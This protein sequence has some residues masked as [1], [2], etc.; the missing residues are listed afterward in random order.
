MKK[1]FVYT[2]IIAAF[3][4]IALIIF[5]NL[6]QRGDKLS[7]FTESYR[8]K[9]EITIN[10]AGELIADKSVD[11]LGPEIAQ[12]GRDIRAS[13]I[14]IQ[15]LI[16]EGTVVEK[17]DY[18]ATLDRTQYANNLTDMYERLETFK[19]NFEVRLLDTAVILND[20]RNDIKNQRFNVSEAAMTLRNSQY[21]S[22][23]IIR[24][25]EIN[26][27]QAQRLLGQK[28]KYYT[29]R[30]AQLE[31]DI[32]LTK[33]RL[34]RVTSS[35]E[36]LEDLIASFTITAPS[37]GMVIYKRN[38]RGNK[39]KVGSMIN[40]FD[41]AVATLPDLSTLISRIYINEIDISK[42]KSGQKVDIKVDAFPDRQYKGTVLNVANIG[43]VLPN[44]DSKMFEASI[45]INGTD[46]ELRPSMTTD[47][48]IYIKTFDDIVYIP[49][50]CVRTGTDSIPVVYTKHGIK[51][52]VI[53]GESNDKFVVIEQGL[54]EGT[55]LYIR[56]PEKPEKFKLAGE[57]L[58]PL[59]KER[60][61]RRNNNYESSTIATGNVTE[62]S[63]F[64]GTSIIV[65]L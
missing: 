37:P 30:V 57:E 1:T 46:P 22:P 18:I 25:A 17:G 32:S 24:Q 54:E 23:S 5:S 61:K 56:M 35:I 63:E 55:M 48:K 34:S 3:A 21:E 49:L 65:S 58:I 31:R 8:G 15:D 36:E 39:I 50:D 29:L 7:L 20:L 2:G 33:L 9:F 53:P 40:A 13:N 64:S 41:R 27:D 6:T 4:I 47:N 14:T 59:I 52:I 11:I 12:R 28:E 62:D 60:R 19:T 43:E 38:R 44:S 42:V 10:T 51:Q 45:K 16:P 26:L